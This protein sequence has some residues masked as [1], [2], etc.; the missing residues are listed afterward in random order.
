MKRA[1]S[2]TSGPSL[3]PRLVIALLVASCLTF[4]PRGA[5]AAAFESAVR[6]LASHDMDQVTKAVQ[7]LGGLGDPRALVVL[8]ALDSDELRVAADGGVYIQDG[9]TLR[10]AVTG[11]PAKPTAVDSPIVDNEIR[12]ALEP[13]LS[14]LKLGSPDV[15]VRRAAAVDIAKRPEDGLV[16]IVKK[17]LA[18]ETDKEIRAMLGLSLAQ[19]DLESKDSGRRLAAV[20]TVE[21]VGGVQLKGEIER[22]TD[23]NS[24]GSF[25]EPD[26]AVRAAAISALKSINRRIMMISAVADLFYGLSL[27]SVLLL[28]AL[29]LAITFGLMGVIN[30][31]HGEMLMIGAYTTYVVQNLFIKYSPALLN[32]YLV[33]AIPAAFVVCLVVGMV[34]ERGVIRFLYGRPLE[35]LLAT[36]GISLVLIQTVRVLFGA[37]NVTVANPDWLSGGWELLPNVVLPYSRIAVIGFAVLVVT[38]VSLLLTRTRLGLDVRAVTQNRE[39]AAAMGI[40]TRRVDTWTFGLGSAVAGLGGVA[41]SQLGN[42]GPELGQSYIIDSFMVVVLGGVGKLA[43]TIIGS[44]GLGLINKF[45][46][47]FAGAVLGKI[48]VLV[49]V[50]LVI[51]KR[52]QGIFALKGRAAAESG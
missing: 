10:D 7:I 28:A 3:F 20:K 26:P 48:L 46:E 30:M 36:W 47:P 19:V 23:K 22:L 4:V 27:G 31:A 25:V 50:V 41:L 6:G 11:H 37:Q 34:L 8:Q 17:A 29:G 2:P 52:P 33:L 35:T 5:H 18:T 32:W 42:V 13:A 51:Q 43:G 14:A 15:A 12:R 39:M 9:S 40:P 1:S 49:F 45:L 21:D 44:F 24:D 16:P 38:F